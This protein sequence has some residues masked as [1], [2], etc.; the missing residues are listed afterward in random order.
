MG[1]LI[2]FVVVVVAV[3]AAYDVLQRERE[4]EKRLLWIAI[5]IIFPLLGALAW[6][7]FRRR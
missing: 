1:K 3:L 2:S 4:V 6:V 7:V 5:I